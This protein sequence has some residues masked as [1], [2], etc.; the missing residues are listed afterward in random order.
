[1]LSGSTLDRPLFL[2]VKSRRRDSH[3]VPN[4][5]TSETT[6]VLM[7]KPLGKNGSGVQLSSK[8]KIS[9]PDF[10]VQDNFLTCVLRVELLVSQSHCF[11]RPA[12]IET[13]VFYN[14]LPPSINDCCCSIQTLK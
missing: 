14:L 7:L 12:I 1:M 2:S 4:L 6:F 9:S 3:G 8:S 13:Y 5:V 11:V 10:W